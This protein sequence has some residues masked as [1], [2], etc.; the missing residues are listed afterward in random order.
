MAPPE[1]ATVS[2]GKALLE[3]SAVNAKITDIIS[4]VNNNLTNATNNL[5][6]NSSDPSINSIQTNKNGEESNAN[7]H[8]PGF[9]LFLLYLTFLFKILFEHSFKLNKIKLFL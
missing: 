7:S 9:Y 1:P 5:N 8:Q 4:R 3:R 2:I 6:S